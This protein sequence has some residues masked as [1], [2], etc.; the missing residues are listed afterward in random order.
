MTKRA[1]SRRQRTLFYAS[2]LIFGAA[3]GLLAIIIGVFAVNNYQ[4]EKKLMKLAL[5][6]EARAIIN[7]V[8]GGFRGSMRRGVMGGRVERD[9]LIAMVDEQIEN[10]VDY[11]GLR[12]LYLVDNNGVVRAHSDVSYVG[13]RVDYISRELLERAESEQKRE[14]SG[15][16]GKPADEDAFFVMVVRFQV[17]QG[18]RDMSQ[19]QWGRSGRMHPDTST[20]VG[21]PEMM[22]RAVK[23][24]PRYLV[25]EL[26]LDQYRTAIRK[27]ILQIVILSVVLLL[28]GI[29]GLMTLS[30]IQTYKGSQRRLRR[31]STFTDIL[32]SSLPIGLMA[33][34]A[35][36]RI[37]TC[38]PRAAQILDF[39]E[40]D[41]LDKPVGEILEGELL[42]QINDPP[43][44]GSQDLSYWEMDYVDAQG[45]EMTLHCTMVRIEDDEEQAPGTMLIVQDLSQLREL[46]AQ[47]QRAERD[48]VVGRMAAGVAHELRNP[49]S[50][51]K[52]LALL[53]KS[54]LD[55]DGDAQQAADL[56]TEQ[57]DRLNR[58]ISE[59]LDYARPAA[60]QKRVLNVSELLEKASSLVRT[61]AQGMGVAIEE[62]YD[63]GDGR[64][65]GDADKLN[66]VF[67][68]LSL[69]AIQ[70]MDEGGTLRVAARTDEHSVI[71]TIADS[72]CGIPEALKPRIF[73]PYFTTKHEGT[74][75]GLAMSAKIIAD[76]GGEIDIES[77]EGQ[78]TTVSVK[79]PA[80]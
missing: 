31:M 13:Q 42:E 6:Q 34:T 59:L 56:M 3:C 2:P 61:D 29:G 79:F 57:V 20:Q 46:E 14:Y 18:M 38:N 23:N 33:I 17:P 65:H 8:L 69:N 11:P 75:L 41:C 73:E 71:V 58:S 36:G 64:I 60:L 1:K 54:K 30:L 7:L 10:S 19:S 67:L 24:V 66:Q 40:I 37:K 77:T 50:S 68:N 32:V 25:T 80:Y 28:V 44:D 70:A 52:G 63:C 47:L 78:G 53:L 26:D 74:G 45:T 55:Q 4:R 21:M 27:Q 72:G 22:E 43:G 35:K 12:A 76:H 5:D 62:D 16:V 15:F 49:L 39:N 9:D 48:A 51:V